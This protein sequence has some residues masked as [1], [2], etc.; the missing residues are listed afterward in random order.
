MYY[1][2]NLL[3]G[4]C[5]Q[6]CLQEFGSEILQEERCCGGETCI[7]TYKQRF[8]GAYELL[9]CINPRNDH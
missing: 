8:N 4:H 2:E 9:M 7:G 1:V 6:G 5:S 3:L